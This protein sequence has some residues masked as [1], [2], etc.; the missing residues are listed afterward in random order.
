MRVVGVTHVALELSSPTRMERYVRDVFGLQ[1]LRQGYWRGEYIRVIGSPAH[2]RDRRGLLHLYDRPF[3]PRGA[4]RYIALA[5]DRDVEAAVAELRRRGVEV[6]GDDVIAAPS[7]LRFRIEG[8]AASRVM[9]V[10]DPATKMADTPVDPAIPCL[11]REIHHVAVDTPAPLPLQD[12][13]AELFGMTQMKMH[14]RRGERIYTSRY[15]DGRREPGTG[16]NPSV[17][18]TFERAGADR[19]GLNHIAFDV[20]DAVGAIGVVESR[21]AKVDLPQDAMIHGPEEIW[22]Q[23][24]SRDTHYPIGHPANDPGVTFLPYRYD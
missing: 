11:V 22:Y 13:L 20:A 9:P 23:L 14:D 10:H 6:D 15:P 3:I 16:R 17:L 18:P 12:W 5:V 19:G 1:L 8:A 24:T 4:L 21:G 7:G 2:A